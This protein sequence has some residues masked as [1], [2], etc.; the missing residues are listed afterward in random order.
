M[1]IGP[2]ASDPIASRLVALYSDAELQLL[3]MIDRTIMDG[4]EVPD[5]IQLKLLQ[6]GLLT[7]RAEGVLDVLDSEVRR[8]IIVALSRAYTQGAAT[9]VGDL[10]RAFQRN[11]GYPGIPPVE[12]MA[13]ELEN[14]LIGTHRAVLRSVRDRYTQLL[15][16]VTGWAS[17]HVLLG[18][19]TRREAAH[20]MLRDIVQ[21]HTL[22][23][24]VDS[25]GR[26]WEWP[27]Y[28]EMAVRT[29][30]MNAAVQGHVDRLIL[31]GHDLVR[32]SD[33]PQECKLCRPWEGKV[34]SLLG[35]P[36]PAGVHVAG[37]L[38]QAKQDGLFHPGCRHS[39]S[40]YIPGVTKLQPHGPTA[41]PQGD[42]DR[43][44]LRYLERKVRKWKMVEQL[45]R[46]TGDPIL[47]RQSHDRV[48][49][50]Q[51]QIR[52]HV[53]TTTATRQPAREQIGKAY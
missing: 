43:Q 39:I 24:F 25:R 20:L 11:S 7:A 1:P 40:V 12:I 2:T 4:R 44:K 15:R 6:L 33:A 34:L 14:D 37:T 9:A 27:T 49:W 18:V 31:N 38:D 36:A 46:D 51:A 53:A 41:D 16:D 21:E 42:R 50:Y 5:W 10:D 22:T 52:Q 28:V 19:T 8:E 13:A 3:R 30:T 48:R 17:S 45:D 47:I 35:A 26:R 29:G 23:A 32:V